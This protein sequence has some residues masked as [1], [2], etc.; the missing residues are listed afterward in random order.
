MSPDIGVAVIDRFTY[1]NLEFMERIG[2]DSAS[3]LKELFDSYNPWLM[4]SHPGFR[5]DLSSRMPE[6]IRVTDFF[7]SV[8]SVRLTPKPVSLRQTIAEK[9]KEK[10]GEG[11]WSYVKGGVKGGNNEESEG[12]DGVRKGMVNNVTRTMGQAQGPG[13]RQGRGGEVPLRPLHVATLSPPYLTVGREGKGVPGELVSG[14]IGWPTGILIGAVL[15]TV[16]VGG[17]MSYYE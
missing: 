16:M 15:F 12:E 14:G 11:A 7:G 4:N 6:E 17:Q 1:Y 3:T 9:E 5:T 13:Q 8:Q 10:K 2:H